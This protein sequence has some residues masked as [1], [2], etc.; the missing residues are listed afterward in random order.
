M[1][2]KLDENLPEIVREVLGDLGN[3]AHTVAQELLGGAA[4]ELVA[5]DVVRRVKIGDVK[6]FHA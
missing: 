5:A 6:D 4:D 3:D 1:R 2:F